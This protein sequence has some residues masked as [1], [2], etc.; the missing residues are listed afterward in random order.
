MYLE[1]QLIDEGLA[2]YCDLQ[3]MSL[4]KNGYI[5][6]QTAIAVN[7]RRDV[8]NAIA[9]FKQIIEDDPYCLDNMDTYSNLL[10]V[11]D[12]KMN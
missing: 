12:K 3:N 9:T 2:L 5:L 7:Y 4:Q 1:L 11:K 10:Y 6:A 8:D